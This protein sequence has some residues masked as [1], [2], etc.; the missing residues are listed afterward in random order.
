MS[1]WQRV[2]E[3]LY[4]Y[5]PTGV[6]YVRRRFGREG[7]PR[8]FE[9]TGET[10]I[11]KAKTQ[12]ERIT[13]RH[14]NKHLG[15]DDTAVF[16][17]RRELASPNTFGAIARDVLSEYTPTVRPAT[18]VKHR[19]Y[20]KALI[21][22]WGDEPAESVTPVRVAAW[23][24]K[25]RT[26]K[27]GTK[28]EKGKRGYKPARLRATFEGFTK[29]LNLVFRWG[30]ENSRIKYLVI[31][32]NP[33]KAVIAKRKGRRYTDDELRALWEQMNEDLRDQFVLAA[34]CYMRLNEALKLEW[35]RVDL[36]TGLV[37]L[38]AEHVKT[39]S[40]TGKGRSFYLSPFALERI[41][42]RKADQGDVSPFIF[43][44][45]FNLQKPRT[46]N[47]TAWKAAKARAGIAG[48]ATWHH[49]RHTALSR[50]LLEAGVNP[51]KVSEYAGVHMVTIQKV[52]LHSRPEE[53]REASTGAS[54]NLP[55]TDQDRANA[56]RTGKG[57]NEK[58]SK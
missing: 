23:I 2:A 32:P 15:I 30:Y 31:F 34:E 8:L 37:T 51:T 36:K 19:R 26:Q 13:Q 39:G 43:P 45:R 54:L 55:E 18:Q 50:A 27:F 3:H 17:K 49:L 24:K 48:K 10:T 41:R 4:R 22:E 28:I 58:D 6:I 52:Y 38:E 5:V 40:K 35:S 42:R 47:K 25:L 44:S 14:R 16:G 57:S 46:G 7:I 33:D 20:L 21:E 1:R 9:T 53:T 11:G 12:A 56:G 29:H